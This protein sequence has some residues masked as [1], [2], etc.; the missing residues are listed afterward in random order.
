MWRVARAFIFV[1]VGLGHALA[2]ELEPGEAAF[3]VFD[4]AVV[5]VGVEG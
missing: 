2:I 4:V 5:M 3:D 1:G